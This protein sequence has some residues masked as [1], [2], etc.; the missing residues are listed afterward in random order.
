VSWQLL[1]GNFICNAQCLNTAYTQ[2]DLIAGGMI[3]KPT[4]SWGPTIHT[5][6]PGQSNWLNVGGCVGVADP[7][8]GQDCATALTNAF[9]CE[10]FACIAVPGCSVPVYP[11]SAEPRL[12]A[13]QGCFA[14]AGSGV[15]S[16]YADKAKS[17]CASYTDA[18]GADAGPAAFCFNAATD[19]TALTT[20][21]TQACGGG[22][23][24]G[25]KN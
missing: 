20:M 3:P 14:A 9:E 12:K 17:A 10:Y 21:L 15:C 19:S 7:D 2:G 5:N 11:A 16:S 24:G 18:S 25:Y 6:N 8:G 22:D 4:S 1:S 23:G 13:L